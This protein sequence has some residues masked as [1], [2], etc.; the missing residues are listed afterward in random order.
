MTTAA[1]IDRLIH[2]ALILEMTGTSYRIEEA[3]KRTDLTTPT[4]SETRTTTTDREE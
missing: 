4:S 1:A 3:E 2:R